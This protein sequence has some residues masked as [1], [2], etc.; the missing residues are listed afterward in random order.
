MQA[1][2]GSTNILVAGNRFENAGA[3]AVQIGGL[4]GDPFFRPQL[5]PTYEAKG[6]TVEHN[7]IVCGEAG[8][9]FVNSDTSVI[10]FNTFHR[11]TRYVI[12][13]PQENTNPG[14]LPARNGVF[15]DNIVSFRSGE[16]A[17]AANVGAG[18]DPGSFQFARNWWWNST[19]PAA[20]APSLPASETGGVYGVDPQFVN[21]DA[22]DL[23]LRAGSPATNYGAYAP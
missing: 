7:L 23:H 4:T 12:R 14:F 16:L 3:R 2:G 13:I 5:L 6:I 8:V 18:T 1:K 19:N 17:A 11:Q 21:P 22:N 10:R 20:S 15:T 9:A